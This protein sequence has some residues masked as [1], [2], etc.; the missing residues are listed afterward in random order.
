MEI[1]IA[2]ASTSTATATAT[3]AGASALLL[4]TAYILAITM[5][6]TTSSPTRT[7]GRNKTKI[8]KFGK[9]PKTLVCLR[10][11]ATTLRVCKIVVL[12]CNRARIH[13]SSSDSR[14]PT[15]ERRLT[16]VVPCYT[17][18]KSNTLGVR[19]LG[20][21]N[22][23]ISTLRC[24]KMVIFGVEACGSNFSKMFPT[25]SRGTQTRLAGGNGW[26]SHS[27]PQ[28]NSCDPDLGFTTQS[29]SHHPWPRSGSHTSLPLQ[30]LEKAGGPW[31][32]H[33]P[34]DTYHKKSLLESCYVNIL[35]R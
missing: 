27:H 2:A 16:I 33:I 25:T 19:A 20:K 13:G 26:Q 1:I 17:K 32:A 35:G 3:V 12:L 24:H 7:I 34:R 11:F 22:G 18:R 14:N 29:G 5:I 30:A 9:V 10:N 4:L 28:A 6:T 31:K 21:K 23:S 8:R 15:A